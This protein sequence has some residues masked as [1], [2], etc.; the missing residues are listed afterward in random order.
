MI[1]SVVNIVLHLFGVNNATFKNVFWNLP[2]E[3]IKTISKIFTTMNASGRQ[4]V[5]YNLD[6]DEIEFNILDQ[7]NDDE[8]EDAVQETSG[9]QN[10]WNYLDPQEIKISL[11]FADDELWNTAKIEIQETNQKIRNKMLGKT[12]SKPFSQFLAKD[13]LRFWM[14]SGFLLQFRE[15]VNETL[16]EPITYKEVSEFV[17]VYRNIF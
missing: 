15:Y 5:S 4:N 8:L 3:L 10:T 11:D 1:P 7:P 17:T 14:F 13:H 9:A 12:N 6:S 16:T 2:A